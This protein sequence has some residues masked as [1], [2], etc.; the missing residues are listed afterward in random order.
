[1]HFEIPDT[2][3]LKELAALDT[4]VGFYRPSNCGTLND[5]VSFVFPLRLVSDVTKFFL[6]SSP[7]VA[8]LTMWYLPV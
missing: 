6:N 3:V 8:L 1:M 7:G 2:N 4:E 5:E